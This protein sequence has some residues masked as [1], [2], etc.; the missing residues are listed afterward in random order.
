GTPHF[1]PVR[2]GP[3]SVKVRANVNLSAASES[4]NNNFD[5][6]R[7]FAAALV[8]VSHSFPL[9][10]RHEPFA[11]HTLGTVGV[12]IFF[13]TSGFLVTRSWVGDPSFR[14]FMGKRIRRI[15]PGLI[16]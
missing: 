14:A 10:G 6:L 8:L 16:V 9:T 1:W 11:P 15:F 3:P 4:R 12:E 13:V 2:S 7:L 5:V